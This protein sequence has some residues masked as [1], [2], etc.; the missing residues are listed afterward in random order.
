ME[1]QAHLDGGDPFRC[2]YLIAAPAAALPAAMMGVAGPA[3]AQCT[4]AAPVNNT[5]VACT[6]TVINQNGENGYGTRTENNL[7]IN[8]EH[9]AS[10][11]GDH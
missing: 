11:C 8:V 3:A 7:T 4:P 2:V 10:V 6:G 5:S 9:G 1:Q